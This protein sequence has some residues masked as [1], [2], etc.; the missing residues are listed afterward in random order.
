MWH[1]WHFWKRYVDHV[2]KLQN[3]FTLPCMHYPLAACAELDKKP[4]SISHPLASTFLSLVAEL[5]KMPR[6][7]SPTSSIGRRLLDVHALSSLQSS[8]PVGRLERVS[9]SAGGSESASRR[10][11]LS[12]P[13]EG[14]SG[15]I[16]ES[17]LSEAVHSARSHHC[18]Q[19][20][21]KLVVKIFGGSVVLCEGVAHVLYTSVSS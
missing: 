14:E 18:W 2:T 11:R 20:G 17:S 21:V 7:H 9:S 4:L 16:F 3:S 13:S 6:M 19:N 15:G 10:A 5:L 12:S 1:L 8:R